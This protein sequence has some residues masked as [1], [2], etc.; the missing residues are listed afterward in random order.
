MRFRARSAKDWGQQM[1]VPVGRGCGE[2][3]QGVPGRLCPVL[4]QVGK[5]FF[6]RE[7]MSMFECLVKNGQLGLLGL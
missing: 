1:G 3:R 7:A 4:C 6:P 5:W 2:C